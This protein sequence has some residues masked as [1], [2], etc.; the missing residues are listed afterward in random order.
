M[1]GLF[2]SG[3]LITGVVLA[4]YYTATWQGGTG[5]DTS[6]WTGFTYV[7]DGTWGTTTAI[8][9]ES[10]PIWTAASSSYFTLA[11]WNATDTDA[12]SEGSTNLYY[13]NAR[14]RAAISETITGISYN[15]GTGVLS[16]T[17]NYIIPLTASTTDWATA[18]S[19]GDWSGEGF[20][21]LT[22]LSSTATGLTYTSGTGVFSLTA[23]YNIPLTASTTNWQ[24]AYGWGDHSGQGYLTSVAYGDLTGNPSDVITAGTGLVW[25]IDTLN[26]SGSG[27]SPTFAGLTVSGGS[28]SLATT[29]VTDLTVSSAFHLSGIVGTGGIDM[30][31]ELITNIG[32][33]STDFITGGGL[34]LAGTLDVTGTSTFGV[35][36]IG[37]LSG[38]LKATA[39]VVAGSATM[40][41]IADGSTYFRSH[42]DFTDTY[43]G[44][45]NQSVATSASPS[46]VRVYGT[47]DIRAPIFYDHNDTQ[48]KIDGDGLSRLT[49]L[50]IADNLGIG[51]ATFGTNAAKVL[52]IANGTLPAT[53]PAD[54]IQMWAADVEAGK[55]VL[56]ILNEDDTKWSSWVSRARAYLLPS[57]QTV[58]NDKNLVIKLST[59]S[60]DA[61]GEFD[62]SV[63]SGTADAT[64]ANKLH[65]TGKFTEAAAYYVGRWVWNK[66]DNTYAQVTAKDSND[67][68]TLDRDIMADTETYEL[69][70]SKFTAKKA[71]Y[72]Q[73]NA[74]VT[75]RSPEADKRLIL[76]IF[77]NGTY[78]HYIFGAS[79]YTECFAQVVADKIYLAV[80]DYVQLGVRNICTGAEPVHQGSAFTF[81]SIYKLSD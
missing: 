29:T 21:A 75:W 10:D 52:G 8:T 41:D 35:V 78:T 51:T 4:D 16:L 40:D 74:A 32:N 54:M 17:A 14:A 1:A 76:L 39:G 79:P 36:D 65:D 44:Y 66:I 6:G 42:N 64:A 38:V 60:Y 68:L 77:K 7:T 26:W 9:T 81:L 67:Q 72:Y 19:W 73:I 13:T 70:F 45:L 27:L 24:T 48:Y 69:Y 2:I 71:G 57:D 11:A 31:D 49:D 33:A 34:T 28:T 30:N 46:F 43:K 80:N 50:T 25:S 56:N 58:E 59:E 22:D 12:L 55:S 15:S 23:G 3:L 18:Y 61:Q 53:S 5:Q 63:V 62:S 47:T 37:S 20:I